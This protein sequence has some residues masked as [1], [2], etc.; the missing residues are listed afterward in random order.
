MGP[1]D[2]RGLWRRGEGE[3][4]GFRLNSFSGPFES[5]EVLVRI[6]RVTVELI[7][8]RTYRGAGPF[9]WIPLVFKGN[10]T[11]FSR[12]ISCRRRFQGGRPEHPGGQVA[13]N[14]IGI[15]R[16]EEFTGA[17][18]GSRW[19]QVAKN[20]IWDHHNIRTL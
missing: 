8:E 14:A 4:S 2:S 5:A 11:L 19:A 15:I 13:Q 3:T 18:W 17:R 10:V 16:I 9:R 6:A 12:L 20:A 7:Y 1:Y